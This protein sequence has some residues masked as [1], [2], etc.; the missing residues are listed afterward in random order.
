MAVK[1]L[2]KQLDN[3]PLKKLKLSTGETLEEILAREAHRLY[4]CIQYYIDEY[5]RSYEPKIYERSYRYQG[6]LYAEDIADIRV[7]GNTIR[8]GVAFQKDLAIQPNLKS[9]Y[10]QDRDDYLNFQLPTWEYWIPIKNKHESFVP[11]L[12]EF[13]WNAPRLASMIGKSVY[14][15]TYFEGIHAVE[16]GIRDF[17][18]TNKYGIKVDAHDFFDGKVY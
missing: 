11:L 9:V 15:L 2:K 18:K 5:Y 4:D 12:M 7:V 13:G 3:L 16:K 14:R 1:S 8:I 10:R 6:A 17:N